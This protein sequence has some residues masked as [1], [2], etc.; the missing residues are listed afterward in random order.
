M[1]VSNYNQMSRKRFSPL[2]DVASQI[3]IIT[4][5]SIDGADTQSLTAMYIPCDVVRLRRAV[6]CVYAL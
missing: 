4:V 3:I 1:S 2:L 6:K 5:T